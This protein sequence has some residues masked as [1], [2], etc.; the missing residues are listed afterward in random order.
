MI[1]KRLINTTIGSKLTLKCFWIM[2][3]IFRGYSVNAQTDSLDFNFNFIQASEK[4]DLKAVQEAI[5]TGANLDFQD[6]NGSTA[7]FYACSNG[8]QEIVKTLLY[9]RANPNIANYNGI[10]PLINL[11]T[12]GDLDMAQLLLYDPRTQVDLADFN[13]ATALHYAALNGHYLMADMLLFYGA[14]ASL[15]ACEHSS[16]LLLA[17]YNSDTALAQLFIRSANNP[18]DENDRHQSA[19][20]N[21]IHGKDDF[22]LAL[23][24]NSLNN[25]TINQDTLL[26]LLKL[27]I[28]V[29]NTIAIE[30]L[31]S[32]IDW[33]QLSNS[34]KQNIRDEIYATESKQIKKVLNQTLFEDDYLP[35]FTNYLGSFSASINTSEKLY[36]FGAGVNESRYQTQFYLH[37]GTRF[38]ASSIIEKLDETTFNQLWERRRILDLQM[39]KYY[40]VSKRTDFLIKAYAAMAFQWHFGPYEGLSR[41]VAPNFVLAPEVGVLVELKYVFFQA[42]YQYAEIGLF[43]VSP[44]YAKVGIGFKIPQAINHYNNSQPCYLTY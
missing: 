25:K 12:Y 33:S 32:K 43:D 20:K 18:L 21:A 24:F 41:R 10:T 4:G 13:N 5:T 37:F 11:A 39:M 15:L 7:I 26:D 40:T 14:N 36:F 2:I 42:A 9:Y 3:I 17:S 38:K 28:K 6:G 19:L 16:T 22:L 1:I 44:H 23:Y 30:K 31:N 8:H 34:G 29:Q 35:Q 27:A